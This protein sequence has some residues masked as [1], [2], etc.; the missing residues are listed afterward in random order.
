MPDVFDATVLDLGEH[1]EPELGAFAALAGPQAEDVALAVDGDADG[2]VDRPVGDLAVA[3]LDDHGVDEDHRIDALQR[4]GLPLGQLTQHG[5]GDLGDR[6]PRHLGAVHVGE[7]GLHLTRREAL[8]G[9]RDDQL[10][11]P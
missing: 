7:V 2:G 9:E 3:D 4:A 11:D 8:G 5:V 10:I 6:L 1:G